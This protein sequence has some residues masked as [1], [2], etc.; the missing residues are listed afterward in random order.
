MANDVPHI[1]VCICTYKRPQSLERLLREL[2]HQH[3]EDRFTYSIVV[4]DN[5]CLESAKPVVSA[6]TTASSIPVSYCVEPQ[7]NIALARN[8]AV[9]Q[10]TGDLVAFIDDDEFPIP[11]WLLT[12]YKTFSQSNVDG[13]LGPVKPHF[14]EEPPG[15]VIKGK[16]YERPTY[17]TGFVIDW[18]KGRTGNV[19]LRARLFASQAPAFRPDYLTG[20][21]QDFFRRMIEK[22]H[23]FVWCDEAVA[24]EVVPPIRWKRSFMLKRA[25]LRGK[26]SLRHPT[27]HTLEIVKSAIAVP[28]YTVALP[29]LLVGGQHVFMKYLV[30]TF[31]HAGRLLAFFGVDA[32]KDNYVT[33]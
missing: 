5:D 17:P 20:E 1:S 2:G 13:V 27:S 23:V 33:E 31:D 26:I 28:A 25:L 32:V 4:A 15:W 14:E 21:D 22:G 24:Y 6:F 7:Q 3:T 8:R 10:S 18:R 12:L 29:I 9:E 16:F 11:Q 19:L 30:K